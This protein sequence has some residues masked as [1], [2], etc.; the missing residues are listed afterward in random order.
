MRLGPLVF[1]KPEQLMQYPI[2]PFVISGEGVLT[3][4]D[5]TRWVTE[6]MFL[7]AG[8]K[9]S[10]TV[11]EVA[12]VFFGKSPVWLRKRLW[13]RRETYQVSKTDAGHRRF[14][15]HDI[16]EFAHLLL[17][18]ERISPTQFAMTIRIVKS[19]AILNTYEIGDTGFLLAHWNGA[20]ASRR[21]AISLV[22]DWLESGD[23]QVHPEHSDPVVERHLTV[24]TR[25]LR[26][27]E[28]RLEKIDD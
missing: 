5:R 8:R 13:E 3:P 6:R 27:A 21:T 16:E 22:M 4:R 15:L 14:G 12:H 28:Q 19:V 26:R 24:A 18:A 9:P 1:R 2:E 20:L 17:Q 7:D 23:A 11:I 25:A 10:Y